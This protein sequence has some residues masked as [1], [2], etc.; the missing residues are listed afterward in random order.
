MLKINHS[1][2]WIIIGFIAAVIGMLFLVY[3]AMNVDFDMS[4]QGDYYKKEV[5]YNNQ[6]LAEQ[7]GLNLGDS[8]AIK[9]INN[10]IVL[11]LPQEVASSIENGKIN[12]FCYSNSQNDTELSLS[13]SSTGSFVF[14]KAAVMKGHNYK[15]SV[16]FDWKGKQYYKEMRIYH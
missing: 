8:F 5:A 15:V 12:F 7:A 16:N 2:N 4:V 3:K 10:Q 1:G 6:L 14:D 13:P 9:D 11:S